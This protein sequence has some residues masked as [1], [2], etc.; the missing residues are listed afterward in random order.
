MAQRPARRWRCIT[1]RQRTRRLSTLSIQRLAESQ[2]SWQPSSAAAGKRRGRG[3]GGGQQA[4]ARRQHS[5][6]VHSWGS[7]CFK[8]RAHPTLTQAVVA[9]RVV[10]RIVRQLRRL[11]RHR[12]L[13]CRLA[14]LQ[15]PPLLL[16]GRST[17]RQAVARQ[18]GARG[19]GQSTDQHS[20]GWPAQHPGP[21]TLTLSSLPSC[22]FSSCCCSAA[23]SL[24]L[25]CERGGGDAAQLISRQQTFR[26]RDVPLAAAAAQA[27]PCT[28]HQQHHI[29]A[30][31]QAALQLLYLAL[32]RH[33]V[34]RGEAPV[35]VAARAGWG[36]YG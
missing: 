21:H 8:R 10:A 25:S 32:Q 35:V 18:V 20:R 17:Q 28:A 13:Q 2:H 4:E 26:C 16:R 36:A 6:L 33:R 24:S 15:L 34:L 7:T 3:G 5:R 31:L 27:L 29:V 11:R 22:A 1:R 23:R 12:R 19:S 9:L 14:L 30:H